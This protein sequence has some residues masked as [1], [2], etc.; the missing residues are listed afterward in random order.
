MT[1]RAIITPRFVEF[2]PKSLED[3]VLYVSREYE[4]AVHRCCCGCGNKVVTPLSPTGWTL[5]VIGNAASLA[6]SIGNWS[7]PCRSH[8]WIRRSK[9]VWAE[10]WSQEK[11]EQVRAGAAQD[12]DA[13]Y[14]EKAMDEAAAVTKAA[15]ASDGGWWAQL[16]RWWTQ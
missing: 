8:Y 16:K 4:T 7:F 3:G 2:I 10:E 1:R 15:E 12:R 6:P 14:R 9:V 11:V 5:T 13:Y